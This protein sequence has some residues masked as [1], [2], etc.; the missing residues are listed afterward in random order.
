MKGLVYTED[1]GFVIDGTKL[2]GVSSV[3]GNYSIPTQE[4]LFLGYEG[5]PNLIQN[6]PGRANFSFEKQMLTS[7]EEITDLVT[8]S[9]FGGAVLYNNRKLAFNSG[10]LSSYSASFQV[11]EIPSSS[12]SF[13]V[14]GDM[15]PN[16]VFSNTREQQG[17]FVPAS[18][19]IMINCDGRQTNRVT[20]FSYSISLENKPAFKI[21]SFY[22]CE[23]LRMTPY[24]CN[25]AVNIEVDDYESRDLY[26]Y[27][28]TGIHEKNIEISLSDKC[29]IN[30]KIIYNLSGAKL[31]SEVLSAS[32]E[33][34]VTVSLSYSLSTHNP[35]S[36]RYI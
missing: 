29:D 16:V 35:P 20:S 34:S 18:S 9:G 8:G 36:I 22:P 28:K 12:I 31:T 19:G 11:D 6:A 2:S 23:V 25:F 33:N 14:Y 24:R 30:K 5:D 15:G 10:F 3:R 7:D 32:T 1:Q 26:G 4:N 13:D 21:G 17:P 27:I